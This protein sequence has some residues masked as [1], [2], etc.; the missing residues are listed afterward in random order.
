MFRAYVYFNSR[1][2]G[3]WE[4]REQKRAGGLC[5]LGDTAWEALWRLKT[6]PE[7]SC[8]FCCAPRSIHDDFFDPF[9]DGVKRQ[10]QCA[11]M[12]P[13]GVYTNLEA[14][15]APC[16]RCGEPEALRNGSGH[17]CPPLADGKYIYDWKER[18]NK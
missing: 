18:Q 17:V 2:D 10:S 3:G 13:G 15:A 6:R 9:H 1:G 8:L 11:I 12:H 16:G 7:L 5:A 4:A 14:Q